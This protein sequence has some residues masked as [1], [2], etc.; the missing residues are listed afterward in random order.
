MENRA[1]TFLL[2]LSFYF[3]YRLLYIVFML[4]SIQLVCYL[5]IGS[6]WGSSL[7]LLFCYHCLH[8][9]FDY[10][11]QALWEKAE[12]IKKWVFL[13]ELVR[14]FYSDVTYIIKISRTL[15]HTCTG[16]PRRVLILFV[17]YGRPKKSTQIMFLQHFWEVVLV[18]LVLCS[19]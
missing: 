11:L 6:G 3:A 10:F 9:Y 1:R 5:L 17:R 14:D 18:L 7:T 12:Y 19:K 2:R 16:E 15:S 8:H 13:G 4:G